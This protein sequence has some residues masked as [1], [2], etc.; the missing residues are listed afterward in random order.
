MGSKSSKSKKND[1][2][3][4][5][6]EEKRTQSAPASLSPLDGAS[7]EAAGSAPAANAPPRPLTAEVLP[8]APPSKPSPPDEQ[9]RKTPQPQAASPIFAPSPPPKAQTPPRPQPRVDHAAGA[10]KP[11]RQDGKAGEVVELTDESIAFFGAPAMTGLKSK[12]WADR[13]HGM[14]TIQRLLAEKAE[15]VDSIRIWNC[16][17]KIV[18]VMLKDKIAPVY[19]ASVDVLKALVYHHVA[20]VPAPLLKDGLTPLLPTLLHRTGNLNVRIHEASI[21]CL[22]SLASEMK[23][24]PEIFAPHILTPIRKGSKNIYGYG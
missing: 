20:Q 1:P 11:P 24:G 21:D 12:V 13:E 10:K 14:K 5:K 19:F 4:R 3:P 18:A 17:I 8:P 7:K 9:T 15:Q 16:T 2:P 6:E 22:L 23:I